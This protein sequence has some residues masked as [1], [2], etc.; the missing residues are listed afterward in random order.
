MWYNSLRDL[1]TSAGGGDSDDFMSKELAGRRIKESGLMLFFPQYRWLRK[2]GA[3]YEVGI[4]DIK[5][6]W[7]RID[8]KYTRWGRTESPLTDTNFF[9]EFMHIFGWP[10]IDR[11]EGRMW[12]RE[13]KDA[14]SEYLYKKSKAVRRITDLRAEGKHQA[15]NNA[16]KMAKEQGLRIEGQDLSMAARNREIDAYTLQAKRMP[17]AMRAEWMKKAE[18]MKKRQIRRGNRPMW[19]GERDIEEE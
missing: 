17:K 14:S 7:Q 13:S 12:M 6:S 2:T 11:R 19:G 18:E 1:Y 4:T 8:D 5:G 3:P 16:M 15:A 10:S 9:S